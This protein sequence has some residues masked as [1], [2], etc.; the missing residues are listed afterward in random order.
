[1]T[2]YQGRSGDAIAGYAY[3]YFKVAKNGETVKPHFLFFLD[4]MTTNEVV[5]KRNTDQQAAMIA[6]VRSS[7]AFQQRQ[8]RLRK[9]RKLK[10]E[11]EA[12]EHKMFSEDE[13]GPRGTNHSGDEGGD[14]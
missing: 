13:G 5:V 14:Y 10:E 3:C 7:N 12:E 6:Q 2:I 8:E 4:G 11:V 1:M 9:K